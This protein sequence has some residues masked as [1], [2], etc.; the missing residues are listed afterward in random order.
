MSVTKTLKPEHHA[1]QQEFGRLFG[2]PRQAWQLDWVKEWYVKLSDF[3]NRPNVRLKIE[4]NSN[5]EAADPSWSAWLSIVREDGTVA[6]TF[7]ATDNNI[8]DAL[9]KALYKAQDRGHF[10]DEY[11]FHIL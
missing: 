5:S 4:S 2:S 7:H 11:I 6:D 8:A 10:A 3:A 1:E 9:K